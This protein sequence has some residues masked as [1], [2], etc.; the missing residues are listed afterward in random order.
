MRTIK[1]T[2]WATATYSLSIGLISEQ[3]WRSSIVQSLNQLSITV[4]AKNLKDFVITSCKLYRRGSGGVLAQALSLIKAKEELCRVY[5]FLFAILI[6]VCIDVCKDTDFID[7]KWLNMLLKYKMLI[8]NAWN[9]SM[10]G[11]FIHSKGKRFEKVILFFFHIVMP[12]NCFDTMK[13]P[14]RFSVEEA[15]LFW[16]N[17]N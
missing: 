17:F 7:L 4:I 16:R 1:K 6:S 15:L 12:S 8:N 9:F 10:Y 3:D 11:I 2:F 14:S 13:K 5:D